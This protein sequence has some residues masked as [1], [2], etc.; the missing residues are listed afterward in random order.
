MTLSPMGRV[1]KSTEHDTIAD[2]R[3]R[4]FRTPP[5]RRQL[6]CHGQGSTQQ[7][8]QLMGLFDGLVSA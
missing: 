3:R 5:P 8:T 6:T 1:P 4:P 2:D 7:F